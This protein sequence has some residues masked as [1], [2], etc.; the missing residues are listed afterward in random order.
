MLCSA[1]RKLSTIG[2]LATVSLA[3]PL[4]ADDGS[5]ESLAAAIAAGD[6]SLDLRYRYEF[7]D[8]DTFAENANASTL[9]LRL[10]Y[11]TDQWRDWSGFLEFDHVAEVIVD[12]FNSGQGTSGPGRDQYPGVVDPDGS[13]LNQLYLQFAPNDDWRTRIG[14]QRILLDNQRFVG[15]VGWRQ[16]EQTYDAVSVQ[17][18]GFEYTKVFYS[19]VAN[20]NRI[21]GSEV[22]AGDHDQD[23]HL[24]N[25]SVGLSKDWTAVGYAYLIDND[26]STGFSTNTLGLR[27][28]GGVPLGDGRLALLGE[29]AT[30]SEAGDATASFDANYLHVDG[31]W[32][33][34]QLSLGIGFESLGS[35]NDQ[36]FRTPLATLHAFNGWAD[37]FLGTP[38]DGLEDLYVTLGYKI[39]GWSLK[40]VYHDF[41]ADAGSSDFGSEID[42]SAGR[43][44]GKRYKL[45]LKLAAFDADAASSRSDTTKAWLML[46]AGF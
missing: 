2:L 11:K 23:T 39:E 24:L 26:D 18:G 21:F 4:Q 15:G 41:S 45:L 17:Y 9:R 12:D 38:S 22:P 46:T 30:Q 37:Q 10:N 36:G 35:D 43:S 25:V 29:I 31:T 6:A 34:E 20:A 3:A 14:R 1:I 40:L 13:D 16:N 5:N 19:Y 27:V 28:N 7:V 44:I 42:L 32:T 33:F 8:Q